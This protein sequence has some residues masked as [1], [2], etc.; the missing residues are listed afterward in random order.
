MKTIKNIIAA[1]LIL[2]GNSAYQQTVFVGPIN[3]YNI[4]SNDKIASKMVRAE[5]VR[6]NKFVVL[7]EFDMNEVNQDQEFDSCYS[8]KC[9][10]E[11]GNN[12]QA[13][14]AI[15]GSVDKIGAK[16]MISLKMI[17]VHTGNLK[18]NVS[19]EFD[20]Q[21]YE[22][23]RMVGIMVNKLLDQEF[24]MVLY[25]KLKFKNEPII[26]NNVGRINNS[27][28]RMGIAYAHGI[29]G[30][31]LTRS[32]DQGGLDMAPV[33]SNLGYQFEYQ[34]VGTENFSSLVEIIPSLNGL[35]QGKFL[36]S[37]TFMNG[38]RFG[39]GGWE[40]AF[41]P[42]FGVKKTSSGFFDNKGVFGVPGRYLRLRDIEDGTTE[43]I[44]AEGYVLEEHLDN[45]GDL[46]F[47][48]RWVIAFGRTFRSGALNIPVNAYW[49]TN[50]G[51]GILGL[52]VGFNITR[53]KKSINK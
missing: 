47:S 3:T 36:P 20:D 46:K 26:S 15:S 35:E 51:G 10:V 21:E 29:N 38:F 28:P 8:K 14:Y 37:L 27:G 22:L 48:T 7:D 18:K 5:V 42:S 45:R 6:T 34:Y 32:E 44:E 50:R 30:E 43:E 33:M 49:S 39:Q 2:I 40:F 9:L 52:S 4:R 24:D 19:D 13:D 12:L 11:Y 1:L 53:S 31:F 17:D 25:E 23:Q 41:G 16:I